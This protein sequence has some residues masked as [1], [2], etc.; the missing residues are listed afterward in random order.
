LN[1]PLR[2][3]AKVGIF[4]GM[5]ITRIWF[6]IFSAALF[7]TSVHSQSLAPIPRDL[8]PGYETIHEDTLRDDL[9]FLASDALQ[10]RMSLQPGDDVAIQWIASEFA[11]AGLQPAANG[12]YLQPVPLIEYRPDRAQNSVSLGR[13][14]KET[15][16][17][18]PE[19]LGSYRQDT[20]LTAG[21]VFA[22]FGITAPELGYDDYTRIDASERSSSFS[23]TN[24]R[25]PTQ[26]PSST[27]RATLASPPPALKCS[28]LKPTVLPA[29]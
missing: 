10:G 14:G 15:Q 27:G 24:R 13:G 1:P 21:V 25:K 29:S 22:G 2:P 5:K 11:K 4:S 20:D 12:S 26:T 17:K 18:F 28:T 16:W 6:F 7:V 23:T 9:T 8:A 3:L 19:V